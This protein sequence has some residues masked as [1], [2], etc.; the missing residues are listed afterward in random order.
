MRDEPARESLVYVRDDAPG[1]RRVRRGRGYAY[2]W[3]DG[4]R[5]GDA[6]LLQRI[7]GLAIPPAYTDVWI[8]P[9]PS[10]HLQATGR[11]AKGRKQYRYHPQWQRGRAADKFAHLVD[12]GRALP[13]LRRRVA[14]DLAQGGGTATRTAVL[15]TIVR[16][17]DTTLAR[18][19]NEEYV[20]ANGSF[21][22]TTLRPRHARIAGRDVRLR[23]RGKSGV[24]HAVHLH[25][26]AVA[27]I[28]RRCQALPGQE[29]FTYEEEDGSVHPVDSGAVNEYLRAVSGTDITAKDFRPWH[30][31]VL[32]LDLLRRSPR[33]GI[34]EL[35]NE[36]A[37][38]LRNTA[39]VCRRSYVH[40]RIVDACLASADVGD[41]AGPPRRGL[42]APERT[43]LRFLDGPRDPPRSQ[44]SKPLAPGSSRGR[45]RRKAS[46]ASSGPRSPAST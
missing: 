1:I 40:P 23:F 6:A 10:G 33:P 46:A 21:G 43:L 29:L 24:E 45:S 42:S 22:L 4:R 16:L 30:A 27:R 25:D 15:A 41:D 3:P 26:A 12:F 7:A 37:G 38:A 35:L 17:L 20:R 2:H 13:A 32:A 11:D 34:G 5:V 36:V 28:V 18:I 31:S 39:A 8:C 19:G 44:V 9:S 14:R